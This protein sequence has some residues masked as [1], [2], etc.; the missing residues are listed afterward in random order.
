VPGVE[1][2]LHADVVGEARIGHLHHEQG[3]GRTGMGGR[4]HVI[5]GPQ[6]GDVGLRLVQ[7]VKSQRVLA[8]DDHRVARLSAEV[9]HDRIDDRG[10]QGADR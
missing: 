8:A 1:R 6:D 7:V 2:H 9:P 3:V 10:M 5:A 4:V